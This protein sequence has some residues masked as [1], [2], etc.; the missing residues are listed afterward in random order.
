MIQTPLEPSLEDWCTEVRLVQLTNDLR[1]ARDSLLWSGQLDDVVKGWVRRQL[2]VEVHAMG[3]M[4]DIS[5]ESDLVECPPEWS[6]ELHQTW[7]LQDQALQLWSAFHWA[8]GLESFYL[9]RKSELDRITLRMLRVKDSGLS[10]ELYHRVK[11]GEAS[12][13]QL[14]WQYGEGKERF[15]GGLIKNQ[16]LS[17]FPKTLFPLLVNLRSREVQPPRLLGN[18]YVLFQLLD[19]Q[20]LAFDDEAR[21]QLLSEQLQAWM[22]PLVER[23]K[24]HLASSMNQP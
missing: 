16:M 1:S 15:Q 6:H 8:H 19:R 11:A 10:F 9:S 17:S 22:S 18:M 4:A 12:F 13:E 3:L 23:L 20:P 7:L 14:S 2:V 5:E 21:S 24:S